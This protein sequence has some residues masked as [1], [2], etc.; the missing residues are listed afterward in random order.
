MSKTRLIILLGTN[1]S[2]AVLFSGY[3]LL[4]FFLSSDSRDKIVHFFQVYFCFG[5]NV[6][7]YAKSSMRKYIFVSA[8]CLCKC[9]HNAEL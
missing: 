7:L 3:C 9:I 6:M 4:F 2:D 5:F 8:I 1:I